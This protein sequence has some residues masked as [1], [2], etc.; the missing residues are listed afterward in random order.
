MAGAAAPAIGR[1]LADL[2]ARV[3]VPDPG[4]DEDG[5]R[6][7]AAAAA[8][9]HALVYDTGPTFG[10]GGQEGLGEAVEQAWVATR[11]VATGALIPAGAGKVL[12]IAP[13]R[14]GASFA[15][16]ARAALENLARTLSVEWA[17]YGITVVAVAPGARTADGELAELISFLVSTAGDYFT[18]CLFELGSE[19]L[20]RTS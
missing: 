6:D 18:G 7:W 19:S 8:P 11:G 14:G 20:L 10:G 15:A 5:L 16:A 9:L 13:R 2:G 3:P 1:A 12:L 17:R 4:L